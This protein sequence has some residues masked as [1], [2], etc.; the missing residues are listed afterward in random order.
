MYFAYST[1]FAMTFYM[2]LPMVPAFSSPISALLKVFVMMLGEFQM[3]EYFT[4]EKVSFYYF[5]TNYVS[6]MYGLSNIAINFRMTR[7]KKT[8]KTSL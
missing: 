7:A 6:I 3:E 5:S 8:N 1:G 4:I 2:L